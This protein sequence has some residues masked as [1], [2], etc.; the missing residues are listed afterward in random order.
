MTWPPSSTQ[1]RPSRFGRPKSTARAPAGGG[2]GG[3]QAAIAAA[4]ASGQTP[5]PPTGDPAESAAEQV[6]PG[7]TGVEDARNAGITAALTTA[8]QGIFAGQS[9]LINLA[10]DE[11]SKLVLRSPVALTVQFSSGWLVG[12]G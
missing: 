2:G 8:K 11:A 10:G 7:G 6:T 12:G 3:R 9:A 1:P 5:P 4:A